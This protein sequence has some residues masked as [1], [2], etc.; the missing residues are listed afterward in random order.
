MKLLA[1]LLALPL[2]IHGGSLGRPPQQTQ[3]EVVGS[4]V[5]GRIVNG[6][7]GREVPPGLEVML[8]SW[9]EASGEGPME[10]GASGPGGAFAFE[11]LQIVPGATYAAMALYEGATYFS[12]PAVASG[13]EPLP[14]FEI[15]IYETTQDLKAVSV[16]SLHVIFEAAQGGLGVAEIYVLSN[17]G[18]HTVSG[19]GE[20]GAVQNG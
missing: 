19:A 4:Q 3:D 8:H 12:E 7:V 17:R 16:D 15:V 13:L 11:G 10:H 18:D 14:A 9:S 1:L 6:T 5:T 2:A 20:P